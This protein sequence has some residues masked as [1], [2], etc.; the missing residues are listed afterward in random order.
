MPLS[1]L[2]ATLLGLVI[3]VVTVGACRRPDQPPAPKTLEADTSRVVIE[4]HAST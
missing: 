2:G 4:Q 3:L 1:R